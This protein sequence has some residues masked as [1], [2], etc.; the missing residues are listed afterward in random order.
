VK[1]ELSVVFADF[2]PPPG[3]SELGVAPRV[4]DLL[5][6]Y[7]AV[8]PGMTYREV[9]P[10]RGKAETIDALR[11]AGME[12]ALDSASGEEDLILLSFRS[13]G[14]KTAARTK[15]VRVDQE[16]TDTSALGNS[17][18]RGEGILTNAI[19]EVVFTQ[20]RVFF[21][22]GHGERPLSG[23]GSALGSLETL[24]DAL[25]DDNFVIETLD[26][27]RTPA[28][29]PEADLVIVAGPGSPV[30]GVEA[31][32]LRAYLG[33]GGSVVVMLDP[34]PP[35]APAGPTG[36][37]DLLA[38]FGI[39]PRRDATVVS[40]VV[41]RTLQGLVPTQIHDVLSG[42][43]EYGRHAAMEALERAGM[44]VVFPGALPVFRTDPV[45][46]GYEAKELVFAPRDVEG[47][48]PFGSVGP[49]HL[50]PGPQ[51]ITDRRLS[52]AVASEAK[53]THGRLVVFGD[54][55][56][57]CDLALRQNPPNRT[58][59]LN[60]VSW[61]VRR[62]LVAIDPKTVETEIVTLRSIDREF[63]YWTAVVALPVITLGIALGVWWSR[64][65]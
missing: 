11:A 27:G 6:A 30:P 1:G 45:P 17:R 29:P 53:A 43:S 50:Q 8:C 21:V 55:D 40:W 14:E 19:N 20:R 35:S 58:L 22:T 4:R 61:A 25:R 60:V 65:R 28:V 39:A 63:A 15:Q 64:R 32:A 42:K 62:D 47:I 57:A 52:L 37:E 31:E 49:R 5:R 54:A 9:D 41:E 16:F 34:P 48:K 36:L 12:N 18:F 3:E 59:L 46:D 10:F 7:Q 26:L 51:D 24:A 38:S 13:A 2:P 33:R 23:S 56:C 44:R